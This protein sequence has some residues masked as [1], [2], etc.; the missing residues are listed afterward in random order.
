MIKFVSHATCRTAIELRRHEIAGWYGDGSSVTLMEP[1]CPTCQRF[2]D[3]NTLSS[4]GPFSAVVRGDE[5]VH[6]QTG[7]TRDV[8]ERTPV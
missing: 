3:L 2:V 1:W 8:S 7:D 4:T 5:P 6:F